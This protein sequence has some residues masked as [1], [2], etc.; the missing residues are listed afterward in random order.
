ML[1]EKA[2]ITIIDGKTASYGTGMFVIA[3]AEAAKQGKSKDEI[4]ELIHTLRKQTR[5][6]FLVDTL[7][8]LHKGGR[9]GKASAVFGSLLN[10]KP[11]LS[12]DEEGEVYAV[13]RIRGSKRAMSA[14]SIC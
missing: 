11:I 2:D 10:I 7:E 9:I 5:L 13:D 1:E 3:A 12:I 6:Y 8:Y 4:V 14:S